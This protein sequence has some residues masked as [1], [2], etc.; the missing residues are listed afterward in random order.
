VRR[1]F[2]DARALAVG[3][4]ELATII[5]TSGTTGTPKGAMLT[6]G[7]LASNVLF[8]LE[9]FPLSHHDINISFLPLSH[10][11]DGY[12]HLDRAPHH[13]HPVIFI[14]VD[15]GKN[16]HIPQWRTQ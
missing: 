14:V 12:A 1:L 10:I 9:G 3:P 13:E 6:H 8:S 11:T 16:R 4:D 15:L 5:Y 7:N 2:F